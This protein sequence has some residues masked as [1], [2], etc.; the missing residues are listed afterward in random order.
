MVGRRLALLCVL[1]CFAC[2][3]GAEQD[4]PVTDCDR[5]AA[6]ENG[7]DRKPGVP[8]EKLD[9]TI[10]I[11]ACE[12]AVHKYPGNARLVFQLGRSYIKSG[13]FGAALSRYRQ[14]AER[15]YPPAMSAM[16]AM[17]LGGLGVS[18]D[19]VEAAKWYRKAAEQGDIVGQYNLGYMYQNGRGVPLNYGAALGWYRKAADQGAAPAQ[20]SIGYLYAHGMGVTRDDVEGAAWF[21]RA[22]EQ[23]MAGA[24]Y[25]LGTMYENGLGVPRDR[26]QALTW[27]TKA[28]DQG[29]EIA[30]NKLIALGT[31]DNAN[32]TRLPDMTRLKR[33]AA[34]SCQYSSEQ[35]VE[36]CYLE[37]LKRFRGH[38]RELMSEDVR[39]AVAYCAH[40]AESNDSQF[41]A[42]LNTS[43]R[44]QV[45]EEAQEVYAIHAR[46]QQRRGAEEAKQPK[47]VPVF[48]QSVSVVLAGALVC[49]DSDTIS[50]M[51][52]LYS[53][54]WKDAQMDTLT[55]GQSRLLHGP[56]APAPDP[57]VFGCTLL[58]P[59]APMMLERNNIVPVVTATLPDGT[60]IRGVTWPNMIGPR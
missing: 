3:A 51:Y 11:P 47:I 30:K 42:T 34:A 15:G 38:P 37:S 8:I 48:A 49:P 46:E 13:D 17:Y 16:G 19:E 24:Q 43:Y 27:Y 21:R 32:A 35:G 18:K 28:A 7:L 26:T 4:A 6:N 40:D 5:Y 25:N 55:N 41:C 29:S 22:A 14:A 9:P 52:E 57:K 33:Q 59:G 58:P 20:D 2:L 1:Q 50:L 44:A 45:D 10:A 54:H 60:T 12:D 53:A 39:D 36:D 23:G 56:P 31:Q